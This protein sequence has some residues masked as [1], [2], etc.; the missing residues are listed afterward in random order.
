MDR[1]RWLVIPQTDVS[2]D[3]ADWSGGEVTAISGEWATN[4]ARMPSA[5]CPGHKSSL[6]GVDLY[7]QH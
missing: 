1:T 5:A 3:W 7:K 2:A 4:D 6:K